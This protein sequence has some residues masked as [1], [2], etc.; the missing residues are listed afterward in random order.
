MN[1]A[2]A[3]F[4]LFYAVL[5]IA[6]W[7]LPGARAR[8]LLLLAASYYFYMSWDME[9]AA[10]IAFSTAVDFSIG[11]VLARTQVVSR[12]KAALLTSLTVNL[13]LLCYFKY[14]GF[15]VES[16][17][18]LLTSLGVT[19]QPIE[20]Q[21]ILPVGI[22]FYTF[23][24]L[25]YTIDVYRRQLE[26]V[27]DP[28]DFSLFVAFFPQLVAGPIVRAS[29]F[30]P[31]LRDPKRFAWATC[32][33]GWQ[34]IIIGLAK[35]TALADSFALVSNEVFA[36][37]EQFGF[38]GCWFGV[39]AFA[40]QIYCDFSAY[41]DIAIGTAQTFGYHIPENFKHPYIACNVRDFWRRWHISLST[42]LRDYVYIPLGGSRQGP[43][44]SSLNLMATMF[45]GGLWHGAAWTFVAWGVLHGSMLAIHRAIDRL[46]ARNEARRFGPI[47]GIPVTFVLVCF[48]WV[49]FRAESF[50]DA[51][52]ILQG[53]LGL[54]HVDQPPALRT[55]VV[56][57][58][59][60]MLLVHAWAATCERRGW[61]WSPP[62]AIRTAFITLCAG[63]VLA[64]A[65]RNAL[66]F[67][68]FQF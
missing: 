49:L 52:T 24:T 59:V 32:R 8:K 64:L 50:G 45:L 51:S 15:F 31:Q 13:G 7:L 34:R 16:A 60:A 63:L 44:R 61:H 30:L 58:L 19:L 1:F 26:P 12:R 29:H 2:S 57:L 18:S 25:S 48:G 56:T 67:I 66:E 33:S 22:S 4:L 14:A 9:F 55:P 37:P 5:F 10:L 40:L 23:Q 47:W 43:A 53:L 54:R 68:Y 27:R 28:L 42:W 62:L 46:G 39:V 20:L 35:K 3:T 36:A 65:Q 11:L 38:L 21:I 6:Y 17:Y 41:S